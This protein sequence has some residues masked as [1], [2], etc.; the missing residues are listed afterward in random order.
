MRALTFYR[1]AGY[2]LAGAMAALG[3]AACQDSAGDVTSAQVPPRPAQIVTVGTTSDLVERSFVARTDAVETVDLAFRVGGQI[4]DFPAQE[5][6]IVPLGELLV[7]L[8]TVDFELDVLE[9]E[10]AAELSGLEHDRQAQLRDRQVVAQS[11][12]DQA[13]AARQLD[14][15][16]LDEARQR[17]SYTRLQAPFD[18]LV[19]RR[20]VG[21]FTQVDPGTPVLRVQDVSEIRVVF[22]VPEDLVATLDTD[23]IAAAEVRLAH[24]PDQAFPLTFRELRPEADPVAQT[25]QVEFAMER[26]DD[27]TVLPGMTGSVRLTYRRHDALAGTPMVPTTALD[28]LA[29]GTFRIWRVAA[30]GRVEP[31]DVAV[32]PIEDGMVPVWRGLEVGDR[33]VSAG[34]RALRPDMRVVAAS[35]P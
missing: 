9:A 18:A 25:Y 4:V 33:I 15:V 22:S 21:T 10:V 14:R 31:V 35:L 13:S 8:D 19:T 11:A 5:G 27:M 16:L 17:L 26:P 2:R 6:E 28:P 32:G 34:A 29:N 7:A 23:D 12:Y 3:L 24:R 20:L 1:L 30:D